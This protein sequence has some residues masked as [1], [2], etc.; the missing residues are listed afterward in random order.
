MGFGVLDVNFL[1]LNPGSTAY[2]LCDWG[3]IKKVA[4]VSVSLS[5]KWR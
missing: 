2:R 1:V 3:Q 5:A 4:S